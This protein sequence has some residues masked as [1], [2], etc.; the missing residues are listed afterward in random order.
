[1]STDGLGSISSQYFPSGRFPRSVFTSPVLS[2]VG[3]RRLLRIPRSGSEAPLWVLRLP[4]CVGT[5]G[6]LETRLRVPPTLPPT[7]LPSTLS[8]LQ[9]TFPSWKFLQDSEGSSTSLLR[10]PPSSDLFSRPPCLTFSLHTSSLPTRFLSL[11]PSHSLTFVNSGNL[12]WTV[13]PKPR[14]SS[15]TCDPYHVHHCY[16]STSSSSCLAFNLYFFP[17]LCHHLVVPLRTPPLSSSLRPSVGGVRTLQG[18]AVCRSTQRLVLLRSGRAIKNNFFNSVFY[19]VHR[20]GST[21]SI[22]VET[23]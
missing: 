23:P 2:G 10:S 7:D 14:S 3:S 16:K 4:V 21:Y 22:N 11:C 18:R 6:P 8:L 13:E 19:T 12:P 17:Y 9:G 1:M 5:S 15:R 20:F